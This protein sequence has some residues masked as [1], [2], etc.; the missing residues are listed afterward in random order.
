MLNRHGGGGAKKEIGTMEQLM[1][2]GPIRA[3]ELILGQDAANSSSSGCGTCWLVVCGVA[4]CVSHSV[5]RGIFGLLVALLAAVPVDQPGPR[6]L[7]I[8]TIFT[9][10][11]AG[12]DDHGD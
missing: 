4:A 2:D 1:G 11:A 12:D 7:F 9:H 5:R 8:S 6:G 10:P 3:T